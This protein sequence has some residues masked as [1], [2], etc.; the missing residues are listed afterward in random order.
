MQKNLLL[1]AFA[2][3]CVTILF[4]TVFEPLKA[5]FENIGQKLV[6]GL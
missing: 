1:T 5:L 2:L 6:S 4:F 3:A